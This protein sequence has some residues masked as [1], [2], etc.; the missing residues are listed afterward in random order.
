MSHSQRPVALVTGSTRGIGKACAQA[1]AQQGFNVAI[2]GRDS[3]EGRARQQSMVAELQQF[4]IEAL[5]VPGDVADLAV[6]QQMLDQVMAKWGRL[7]CVVNN[8]GTAAKQRGDLLEVTA[9]NYDY[10]QEVNTRAMFFFCQRAA[11]IML[12]QGERDAHHRSIINITSCSAHSLSIS[13]GEY[14]VSK[15]A[16]SMVTQLFALRLAEEGIGVYE[17]RP[18][19]IE[20]DM[21]STVKPKYDQLIGDG[22][23]PMKRWGQPK[24][25]ATTVNALA[26]GQ[27]PFT[28]GQII[29]IDG[30]LNKSHF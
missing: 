23:V 8:A 18:G 5:A 28:V 19:I 1:L 16:A 10:C 4:D 13:R 29:D 24:D 14:C 12:Q 20:T 27:L 25:I 3:E 21:T 26:C 9:E 15:A 30:G 11:R 6:Q 7:D 17:I 2:N 22:L